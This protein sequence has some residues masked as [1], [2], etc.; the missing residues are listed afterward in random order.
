MADLTARLMALVDGENFHAQHVESLLMEMRKLG[1]IVEVRVYGH[2]KESA[3]KRWADECSS[4][5]FTRVEVPTTGPNSADFQIAIEAVDMLHTRHLD[6]ICIASSDADHASVARRLRTSAVRVVGIGLA[7]APPEYRDCFDEFIEIPAARPSNAVSPTKSRPPA[8]SSTA[9]SKR[10]ARPKG[11]TPVKATDAKRPPPTEQI[12]AAIRKAA[13]S[14]GWASSQK[15]G[16]ALTAADRTFSISKYA[17]KM[18]QLLKR[19]PGVEIAPRGRE[20]WARIN[21]KDGP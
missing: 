19:T 21:L 2:Y 20:T 17:T 4:R 15:I 9:P 8:K 3:M 1:S 16:N 18:K 12:H 13:G 11:G 6:V 10:N 5:R 7:K 14:D